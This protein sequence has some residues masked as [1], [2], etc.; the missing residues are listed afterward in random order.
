VINCDLKINN[1][2]KST[3]VTGTINITATWT[4]TA[5]VSTLTIDIYLYR[6]GLYVSEGHTSNPGGSYLMGNAATGCAS[7]TYQG[8][9]LGSVVFPPG[10]T[11]PTQNLSVTSNSVYISC[12]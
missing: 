9:A 4:C 5:P 1:P 6:N 7:G 12:P 11:P 10:Y 8:V 3:H 2:H